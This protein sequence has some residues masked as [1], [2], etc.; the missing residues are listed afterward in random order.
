ME[1]KLTT[2]EIAMYCEV[3]VQAVNKWIKAGKLKSFQTPGNHK[4]ISVDDFVDT[5]KR[6]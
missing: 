2:R 5:Y 3:T 6:R 1:K 4:R